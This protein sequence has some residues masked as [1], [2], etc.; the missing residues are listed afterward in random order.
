MLSVL[1]DWPYMICSKDNNVN[2]SVCS[3]LHKRM[4]KAV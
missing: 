3:R 4:F 2:T 1:S